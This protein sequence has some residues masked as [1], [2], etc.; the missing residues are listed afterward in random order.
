MTTKDPKQRPTLSQVTEHVKLLQ[1]FSNDK[2][3]SIGNIRYSKPH[4]IESGYQGSVF[5]GLSGDSKVAVKRMVIDTLSEE[6]RQIV[7]REREAYEKL[8]HDN[9][10][11]FIDFAQNDT[12]L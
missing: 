10:V 1:P 12:F 2:L 8:K 4:L 11:K 3:D 9:I 7:D 6:K 5:Y